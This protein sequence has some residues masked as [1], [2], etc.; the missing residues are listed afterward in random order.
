[1]MCYVKNKTNVNDVLH[2]IV[3]NYHTIICHNID[4]AIDGLL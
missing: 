4:A 3:I 2:M 1:M